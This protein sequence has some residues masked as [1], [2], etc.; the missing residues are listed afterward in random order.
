MHLV[1]HALMMRRVHVTLAIVSVFVVVDDE[2]S[3][4][5]EMSVFAWRRINELLLVQA[6]ARSIACWVSIAWLFLLRRK[7]LFRRKSVLRWDGVA[8]DD[9]HWEMETTA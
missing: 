4:T 5:V 6:A 7:F 2:M 9:R 1:V 3:K 8:G